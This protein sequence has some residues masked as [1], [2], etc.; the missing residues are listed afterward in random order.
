MESVEKAKAF[1]KL[2][3]LEVGGNISDV[4]KFKDSRA[5]NPDNFCVVI[6]GI[7]EGMTGLQIMEGLEQ[8]GFLME[9]SPLVKAGC[10]S[11]ERCEMATVE[12]TDALAEIG[13]I[14][15]LDHKLTVKKYFNLNDGRKTKTTPPQG[16]RSAT[17]N[18][19]LNRSNTAP[20]SG[21]VRPTSTWSKTRTNEAANRF[22]NRALTGTGVGIQG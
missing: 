2:A 20:I 3:R 4:R 13:E 7:P 12:N 1:L 5:V 18:V 8:Q 10:S 16:S 17:V 21:R 14:S 22:L 19:R 9:R 6:N 11:I 15:I